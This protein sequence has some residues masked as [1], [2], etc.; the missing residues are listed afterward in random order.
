MLALSL[1]Y[2]IT[3]PMMKPSSSGMDALAERRKKRAR[4]SAMLFSAARAREWPSCNV[5]TQSGNKRCGLVRTICCSSLRE[6]RTSWADTSDIKVSSPSRVPCEPLCSNTVS[7]ALHVIMRGEM[8]YHWCDIV[9]TFDMRL[10]V[11]RGHFGV[12]VITSLLWAAPR[13]WQDNWGTGSQVYHEL[14]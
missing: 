1:S 4:L 6:M 8:R 7:A 10:C 14:F 11:F 12:S 9:Y 5:N 13:V 2:S 3:R